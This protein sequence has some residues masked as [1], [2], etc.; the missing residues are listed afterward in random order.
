MATTGS[1]R[2]N[3]VFSEPIYQA[4]EDLARSKGVTMAEVLRDAISLEK[5]F[6][7]TRKEGSRVLVER[8]GTVREIVRV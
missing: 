8:E 5:W 3:V 7:D 4:L 1:K 2:V 6:E